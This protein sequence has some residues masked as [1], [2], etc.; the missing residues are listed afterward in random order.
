MT[1]ETKG[2]VSRLT[3]KLQDE[4]PDKQ[5]IRTF[6]CLYHQQVLCLKILKMDEVLKTVTNTVNFIR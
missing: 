3:R 4:Y 1:G 6:P 5:K 2:F